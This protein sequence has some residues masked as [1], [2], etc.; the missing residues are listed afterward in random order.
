MLTGMRERDL[1]LVSSVREKIKA[2]AAA[3]AAGQ[4]AP[5]KAAR[6][7]DVVKL[8]D[9]ILNVTLP[10]PPSLSFRLPTTTTPFPS[11][12]GGGACALKRRRWG[13]YCVLKR[14]RWGGSCVP[15][16]GRGPFLCALRAF[17]FRV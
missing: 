16:V 5:R 17:G 1:L 8:F 13:G 12:R 9:T 4:P 11:T 6:P 14:R 2:T 3:A 7:E 10:P 15:K